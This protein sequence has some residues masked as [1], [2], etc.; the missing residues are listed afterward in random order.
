MSV[1][2]VKWVAFVCMG[3]VW[4]FL[5]SPQSAA[6]KVE[7]DSGPIT[8]IDGDRVQVDGKHGA[9]VLETIG[10]CYWCEVGLTVLITFESIMRANIKPFVNSMGRRPVS[11]SS[12]PRNACN[13]SWNTM[14]STKYNGTKSW[15][16]SGWM[17][18]RFS[19]G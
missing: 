4:A 9:H 8:A 7:Y 3:F 14:Y 5:L 10:V 13:I 15:S 17:R 16:K 12:M 1:S 11:V 6:W 18:I 2:R 19:R